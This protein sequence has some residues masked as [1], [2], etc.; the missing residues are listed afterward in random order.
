MNSLIL[1]LFHLD[2]FNQSSKLLL[3]MYFKISIFR[4]PITGN[5]IL[6]LKITTK[7]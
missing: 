6:E 4:V 3:L 7:D 2:V 1:H 5:V